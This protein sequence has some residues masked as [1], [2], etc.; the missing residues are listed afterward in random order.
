MHMELF[1]RDYVVL[2]VVGVDCKGSQDVIA[3]LLASASLHEEPTL[4]QNSV[5]IHLPTLE[6]FGF[7]IIKGGLDCVKC[8]LQFSAV[9]PDYTL[10]M[11]SFF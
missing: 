2:C 8:E 9:S 11:S 10:R 5:Q 3:F 4:A 1:R 7:V 6:I